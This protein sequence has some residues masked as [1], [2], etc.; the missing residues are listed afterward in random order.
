MEVGFD[1]Q[2]GLGQQWL[3]RRAVKLCEVVDDEVVWV[4]YRVEQGR[5]CLFGNMQ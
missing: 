4:M 2:W 3:R 1:V 5:A